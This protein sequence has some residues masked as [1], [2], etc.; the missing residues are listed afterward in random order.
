MARRYWRDLFTCT[1]AATRHGVC[2]SL[3]GGTQ[4]MQ[5]AREGK[6]VN[7]LVLDGAVHAAIRH[8]SDAPSKRITPCAV[9]SES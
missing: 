4:P 9:L 6:L 5:V 1:L 8:P 7:A 3:C 2:A